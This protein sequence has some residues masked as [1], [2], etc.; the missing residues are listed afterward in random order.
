MVSASAVLLG[1]I[2]C[3]IIGYVLS[4]LLEI[5]DA[6]ET[7]LHTGRFAFLLHLIALTKGFVIVGMLLIGKA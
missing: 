4:S 3:T 5:S 7:L 1:L 2:L 6:Y